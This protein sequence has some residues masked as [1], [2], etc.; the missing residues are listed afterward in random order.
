[1]RGVIYYKEICFN[2]YVQ[3]LKEW[4]EKIDKLNGDNI[5]V[6]NPIQST[7]VERELVIYDR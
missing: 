5:K 2:K 7:T 4:I 1:M 6:Q 3:K